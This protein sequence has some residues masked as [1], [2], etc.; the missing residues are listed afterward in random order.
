MTSPNQQRSRTR[1]ER[2]D[3]QE[4][5]EKNEKLDK[6]T[7]KNDKGDKEPDDVNDVIIDSFSESIPDELFQYIPSVM[8][9]LD[10]GDY[11]GQVSQEEIV[12]ELPR[13]RLK[14][15]ESGS[16]NRSDQ[17]NN[18][19]STNHKESPIKTTG[20]N[21]GLSKSSHN[22]SSSTVEAKD[23]GDLPEPPSHSKKKTKSK[24]EKP[25]KPETNQKPLKLNLKDPVK[26]KIVNGI[27]SDGHANSNKNDS[28]NNNSE[29]PRSRIE[30]KVKITKKKKSKSS[31]KLDK[32]IKPDNKRIILTKSLPKK[33]DND[34]DYMENNENYSDDILHCSFTVTPIGSPENTRN[35]S[36][37]KTNR[38]EFVESKTPTHTT[39]S[40]SKVSNKHEKNGKSGKKDKKDA[41]KDIV[42]FIIDS[43]PED[44]L[45]NLPPMLHPA[46]CSIMCFGKKG[47]IP[48]LLCDRCLCLY[49]PECVPAGIFLDNSH[50]FVCPV[51]SIL[52]LDILPI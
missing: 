46:P 52:F 9:T 51:S 45:K 32:S 28:N 44:I 34:K 26:V 10:V 3:K 20:L 40:K 1:S 11:L 43:I 2:S 37:V 25:S 42:D 5:S 13:K 14:I 30:P 29:K 36:S 8:P 33:T 31:A 41:E 50:S 22:H 15:I 6:T 18:V 35:V 23:D 27:G 39:K 4:K 7:D 38:S 24:N 21:G 12:N 17:T 47:I 48:T 19:V 16:T 49:H